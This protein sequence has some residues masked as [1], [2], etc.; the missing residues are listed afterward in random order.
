MKSKVF[1]A[2]VGDDI[3][4]A[5]KEVFDAEQVGVVDVDKPSNRVMGAVKQ[6]AGDG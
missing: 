1:L 5:V 3:V 6:H 4:D 2:L